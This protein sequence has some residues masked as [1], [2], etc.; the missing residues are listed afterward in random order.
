MADLPPDTLLA[1]TSLNRYYGQLHAVKDL[2][3]SLQKG[4]VLGFLGP[5][6]A[7]KS[8]TMQLISG[9][10]APSSGG[11]SINGISLLD[12]PQHAKQYI[13]YL[14]EHPPLYLELTVDEYLRYCAKLHKLNKKL[15]GKAI[16]ECKQ[17]CDLTDCGKRLLANLSKGYQQRVGIA[18]AIIHNPRLVILD[19]P[20]VGL[21]PI[22]IQAIRTL[23]RTIG[24][25]HSVILSSHIL[26]EIQST[27]NRV[28]IIR[29]GQLVYNGNTDT[30]I[31]AENSKQLIASFQRP[32][33][34]TELNSIKG[35]D[36][37]SSQTRHRF[38]FTYQPSHDP[39][40]HIVQLSVAHNWGLYELTPQA[41]SLEQVFT[42]LINIETLPAQ[43][44]ND[45]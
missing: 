21:D 43:V 1:V 28:Q 12:E 25:E 42:Q 33:A 35:I 39:T 19:E 40:E 36:Q 15:I 6:G 22:Q 3:F 16:D 2:N 9:V 18:Q 8:T 32:P 38:L 13:G 4:E 27:C 17:R 44:E 37:V 24:E 29:Q 41:A 7:G 5:N 20:T 14:P 34:L 11:I 10:L 30:L 45:L 31:H 26:P 23:I